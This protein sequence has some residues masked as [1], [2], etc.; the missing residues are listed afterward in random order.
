MDR[1]RQISH[2]HAALPLSPASLFF[3]LDSLESFQN[4]SLPPE[5]LPQIFR[6][7]PAQIWDDNPVRGIAQCTMLSFHDPKS[8]HI[9]PEIFDSGRAVPEYVVAREEC[10]FLFQSKAHMVMRVARSMHCCHGGAFDSKSLTVCNGLLAF[11]RGVFVNSGG[12]GRV[13]GNQ[14]WNAASV[15]TVPVRQENMRESNV[16][17]REEVGNRLRPDGKPLTSVDEEPGRARADDVCVGAL[18]RKLSGVSGCVQDGIGNHVHDY[19]TNI[20]V[21]SL[22]FPGLPPST[23]I[24]R[25]LMRSMHGR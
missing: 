11:V 2:R 6:D 15:I 10:I 17:S 5:S 12:E 8:R 4:L 14:V 24:T 16:F 22:T 23:R 3:F 20:V 18:K 9:L 25:G 21:P 19:W 7:F 1:Q 13:E